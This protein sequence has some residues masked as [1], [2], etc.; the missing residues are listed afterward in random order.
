MIAETNPHH[1]D[2]DQKSQIDI[3]KLTEVRIAGPPEVE[4]GPLNIQDDRD[5]DPLKN[6]GQDLLSN[7]DIDATEVGLGQLKD[8][9]KNVIYDHNDLP[10]PL[11]VPALKNPP[12]LTNPPN[13]NTQSREVEVASVRK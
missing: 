12:V 6:A 11:P 5:R 7:T 4:V 9:M 1:L 3:Q 10:N 13:Q 8:M 2:T